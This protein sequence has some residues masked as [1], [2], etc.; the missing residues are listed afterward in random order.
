MTSPIRWPASRTATGQR[1]S[2]LRPLRRR[3]LP[4]DPKKGVKAEPADV[5]VKTGLLQIRRSHTMGT[6]MTGLVNGRR[7]HG[8][9]VFVR[10]K[11]ITTDAEFTNPLRIR[12]GQP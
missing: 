10:G 9:F 4:A 11:K 3:P 8:L 1:E 7:V 5:D 6:E 12:M 2:T